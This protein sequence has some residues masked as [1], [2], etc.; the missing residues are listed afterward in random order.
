[1]ILNGVLI[2]EFSHWAIARLL[3]YNLTFRLGFGKWYVPRGLWTMPARLRSHQVLIGL[4]GFVG[5][6]F[7]AILMWAS[8]DWKAPIAACMVHF[9]AYPFYAGEQSDFNYF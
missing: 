5:E 7:T 6:F 3:G 1:M 8:F 9:L 2:H 4:A